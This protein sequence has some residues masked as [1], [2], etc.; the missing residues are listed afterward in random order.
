MKLPESPVL[1]KIWH[2]TKA[3]GTPE[4]VTAL[5]IAAQDMERMMP[6][7]EPIVVGDMSRPNGGHLS[8]HRSHRGGLDADIG[9]YYGEGR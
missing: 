7:A 4:L 8:G 5:Q 3:Y 2:P 9:I 1:F 6:E